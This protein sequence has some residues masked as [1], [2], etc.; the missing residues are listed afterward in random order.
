VLISLLLEVH[1]AGPERDPIHDP[2][3]VQRPSYTRRQ[4]RSTAQGRPG[5][6]DHPGEMPSAL[7]AVTQSPA[8]EVAVARQPVLDGDANLLG[9]ELLVD[10]AAVVVDALSEVGLDALTGGHVAWLP[11]GRELLLRVGPVPVRS[12]RVVLQVAVEGHD[13][14][15]SEAV[16]QLAE[17]GACIVLDGVAFDP[18]IEPLLDLAW[19]VKLDLAVHGPEGL[20]EQV[21]ALRGRDLVLIATS[22]ATP[23]DLALCRRLGFAAFQ[24]AFVAEPEIVPGRAVPTRRLDELSALADLQ[25]SVTFEDVERTIVRDVGLSHKL[26]RFA[27]SAL[28]A[29]SQRVGSVR[30]AMMLLGARGVRRWATVL[31][32]A[33]MPD[34]PHVLLVTS[35][36]RARTCELLSDD[37]ARRDRAFTV[38]MFSVINRLLGLPMREALDALPL[39]DDV[40]AALLRGEG[41]E[42]RSLR[43]VLAWELGDFY[44]A[45][46]VT[47]GQ[48]RVGRAYRDAVAWAEDTAASLPR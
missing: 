10:G 21:A 20:R 22:V 42:G 27:N 43:T 13:E 34:Q 16:H 47:G 44:A 24:G 37:P 33:G 17:R 23:D 35:L 7:P 30:E 25:G 48:Q 29:R 41:G 15:L 5:P 4:D 26:L 9:Y 39:S 8:R 12:D 3:I 2:L 46:A 45:D 18:A 40:V 11:V 31:V 14:A 28:F 6:D 1:Y 36:V 38:G 32:L 19:G